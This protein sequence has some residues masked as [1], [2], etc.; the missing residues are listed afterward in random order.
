MTKKRSSKRALLL[1]ALSLL[2]CTT[3]LIG[4]TFAWFTDSVTSNG[5]IIK[6]GTLD[7]TMH[8]ADG[9]KAVPADDS[10][11]WTDASADAIFDYDNWEPGYTEVRHIRI[12]N[13]GSL[14]L[15]YQLN[16][17][18]T[19]EV[20]DLADVID[21]YY[22][23]PAVQVAERADLKDTT[24]LNTLDKVLAGM[25][26]S[27]SG[28]LEAGKSHVVTI[29]LK[30]QESAGNE[31]Q[32]MSIGSD[33]AVQLLATQLTSEFDGFDEQYD[34]MAT[35]DNMEELNSALAADYDLIQL[36]ANITVTE[37]IV[38]PAG[39]TV[40]VDLA[41]YTMSQAKGDIT[42]T[43]ALILNKGNLTIKDSVGVGKIS[44]ADTTP[45]TA[46]IG[47]ASNTIRNE[48]VLNVK[49]G[50][51][52]NL[53]SAEVMNF[54][55]PHAIDC[56][57]GSVTN[58]TSGTVKSLNYDSIRMFCNST[59]KA[60]TVNIDGGTIVNRVSFQNPN[61]NTH[62]AGYGVLN[63]NGGNFITT[64][65]VNA[66]VRLLNFSRDYSNMK[67]TVTG[68][69]F[70]K[71][72]KT[73]DL[74][75][76]G[77]KTS[78]WVIYNSADAVVTTDSELQTALTNGGNIVLGANIDAAETTFTV[79]AGKTAALDLNGH[80]ISGVDKTEK[81]YG[82]I[83][84]GAGATLTINDSI[85][86]GA[87]TAS[88]TVDSGWARYSSVVSNQRGTVIVNGGTIEHKGGTSM[89]YGIDNLTNGKGTFAKTIIN[90]GNIKSSYIGIRQFCNGI[91]A[92]NIVEVNGGSITGAKRSV[93]MQNPS[94]NAN[95]GTLTINGGSFNGVVLVESDNFV[96][97]I[98]NSYNITETDAGK[99]LTAK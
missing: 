97:T 71:G 14:A 52:E 9:T 88:A 12:K 50:T 4:S 21:V 73:Q 65:D 69:T 63:I 86:S 32:N 33:F 34:K 48:G 55:Y 7:V 2:M 60:T 44:F 54:S 39:K 92:Q 11:E 91:E 26:E 58:V 76:C 40:A 27:A 61:N 45:Y 24:K 67:A 20:S 19:G 38:I 23:D 74:A 35:I 96:V 13:N 84:V 56:Y 47:W 51:I 94:A 83:N 70:D 16:I 80:T 75:S 95:T 85:G 18:A 15:K 28:E 25:S 78:D 79:P 42:T 6:S 66:N 36:G 77:V 68:G 82:L 89:S 98:A 53:T 81:S 29:A 64:N 17:A 3:M 10:T 46:D 41:G 8:W 93:W 37:G 90:D 49:G 57:P 22:A 31:Y 72:F 5:N 87:I 62:T 1:S 43:Y 59:D 30:M 99:V